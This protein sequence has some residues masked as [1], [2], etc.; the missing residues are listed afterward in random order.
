MVTPEGTAT[1]LVIGAGSG[2]GRATA[3]LLAESGVDVVAADLN[4][5]AAASVG[6]PARGH[7]H[8]RGPQLGRHRP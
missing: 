2:I 6:L 1:A 4:A 7:R 8:R 3:L 5:E